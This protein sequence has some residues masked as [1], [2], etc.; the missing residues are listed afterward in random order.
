MVNFISY[1]EL[2]SIYLTYTFSIPL[3]LPLLSAKRAKG[4]LRE[5]QPNRPHLSP[6]LGDG[7][8]SPGSHLQVHEGQE[9]D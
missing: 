7:T 5:L 4:G 8:S 6:W 9:G 1:Q 2:R 3:L